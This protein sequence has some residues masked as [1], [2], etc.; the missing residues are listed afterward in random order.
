MNPTSTDISLSM[1]AVHVLSLPSFHWQKQ[2]YDSQYSRYGHQCN[3][4][5]NSQM[6]VTGGEVFDRKSAKDRGEPY[7]WPID[8]PWLMGIGVFDMSN[9]EWKDMYDSDA[10]A[11]TTPEIVKDYIDENGPYPSIWSDSSVA[12][13]FLNKGP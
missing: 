5:G 2:D 10:D 9:L 11:Y 7:G 8:D 4:A 12:D 6:I 13:L 1:G 3:V